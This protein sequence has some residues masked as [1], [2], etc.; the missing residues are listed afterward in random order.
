[1]WELPPVRDDWPTT[2]WEAGDL[3]RGQ[4]SLRLPASLE[5]GDYV[6]RVSLYELDAKQVVGETVDLGRLR[7]DAPERL[8]QAP[9]MQLPLDVEL[10]QQAALLGVNLDPASIKASASLTVTLVWQGRAEMSASLR[11]F[12]HLLAPDGSLL[13]QSDGEPA[14]WTRPTTGWAPGEVILDQRVLHIPADAPPGSYILLAGLYDPST[15]DRLPTPDGASAV[16]ITT[17]TLETP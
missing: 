17:L 8:W 14:A 9:P 11:V 1:M 6:W 15:K 12:L 13:T 5:S 3:W 16:P 4:H 10:G 2:L 7:V